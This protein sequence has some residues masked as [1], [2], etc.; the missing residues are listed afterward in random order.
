VVRNCDIFH[1]KRLIHAGKREVDAMTLCFSEDSDPAME[2]L[3]ALYR[4]L[5]EG[6][7]DRGT[8]NSRLKRAGRILIPS[9]LRQG[10]RRST[11]CK[12]PVTR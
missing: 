4:L 5:E 12:R 9:R 8:P 2:G 7:I 3:K 1:H 6:E 10:R 11:R